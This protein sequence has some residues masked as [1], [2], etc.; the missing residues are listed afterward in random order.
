MSPYRSLL[1]QYADQVGL[2]SAKDFLASQELRI[3]GIAVGLT[4]EGD[5]ENGDVVFYASLGQPAPHVARD[6]LFSLMLEANV[7]WAG[8]GGCT[9]GVQ[10]GTGLAVL[11]GRLPLPLCDAGTLVV[12]LD[13]FVDM[14]LVWRDVVEGRQP[15]VLPQLAA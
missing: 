12:V 2:E 5:E 10:S 14:A 11:C 7:L 3:G 1:A 4:C 6:A 9:L 8:T 15:A 13:A